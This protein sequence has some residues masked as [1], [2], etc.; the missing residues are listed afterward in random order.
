M[1]HDY[2]LFTTPTCP[3]CPRVKE[4]MKTVSMK[5]TFIDASTDEGRHQAIKYGVSAVPTVLFLDA[6]GEVLKTAHS[7]REITSIMSEHDDDV[8]D[9]HG[10]YDGE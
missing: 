2:M 8:H 10:S 6:A 5:G 3:N 9:K 4:H 1:I 7:V